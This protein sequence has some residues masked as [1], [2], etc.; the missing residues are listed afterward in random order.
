MQEGFVFD[1]GGGY[2]LD[3]YQV[4][5]V[6]KPSIVLLSPTVEIA[7]RNRLGDPIALVGLRVG[8]KGVYVV[9]DMEFLFKDLIFRGYYLKAGLQF[10]L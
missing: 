9:G 7:K 5:F 2:G 8:N 6:N 4:G 1:I 10:L 3:N